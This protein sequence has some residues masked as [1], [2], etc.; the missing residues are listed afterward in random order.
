VTERE[1]P[2][3]E[4]PRK[5]AYPPNLLLVDGGQPQL[6]V[7]LRAVE[8]LGLEREISVAALAKRFEEVYLP[9]QADPVRIPRQ[10]EALY[11]LQR[12]RD[13][14]HRFAITYHRTLRAKRMTRSVLDDVPGLGP[15][16]K[17]RLV[18][19]LGGMSAV[20]A[21]SLDDLL[22][23][24]WLPDAVGRAVHERLHAPVP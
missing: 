13:E 2:V 16:R 9:G 15:T 6:A 10:S 21:A 19:E 20:K 11:L 18:K 12:V 3:A 5:F 4:K 14:A 1:R 22:A 24:P 23:L 8:S 7:A 17:K